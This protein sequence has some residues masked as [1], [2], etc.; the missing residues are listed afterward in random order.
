M[1]N[2]FL[3]RIDESSEN[4]P[5]ETLDSL[6]SNLVDSDYSPSM[7]TSNLN[8]RDSGMKFKAQRIDSE[9]AMGN[10]RTQ[11]FYDIFCSNNN[12]AI[13]YNGMI[14]FHDFDAQRKTVKLSFLINTYLQGHIAGIMHHIVADAANL[15]SHIQYIEMEI[16]SDQNSN[17]YD[18]KLHALLNQIG[19]NNGHDSRVMIMDIAP[20]QKNSTPRGSQSSKNGNNGNAPLAID[21]D[22]HP[23]LVCKY[24]KMN[25][26]KW[27]SRCRFS[28]EITASN[29]VS[30][31]NPRDGAKLPDS[32]QESKID[33]SNTNI[34]STMSHY[35]IQFLNNARYDTLVHAA[36][37]VF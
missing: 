35:F 13:S 27:G 30:S 4:I 2:V 25:E 10:Q 7:F 17:S 11:L 29:Q 8:L 36:T 23:K 18:Y 33:H 3:K 15:L 9:K 5:H 20:L 22:N 26:C 12:D 32:P 16:E 14:S 21:S 37:F 34:I 19:F 31:P 24:F 1:S 28:H 6:F